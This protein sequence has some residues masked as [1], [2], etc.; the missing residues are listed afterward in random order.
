MRLQYQ[1][2]SDI[3]KSILSAGL[4]SV[5]PRKLINRKLS[6]KGNILKISGV[7][8]NLSGFAK[9]YTIGIGKGA[10]GMCEGLTDVL[11]E[12]LSGGIIISGTFYDFKTKKLISL[13]GDHPY[14]GKNSLKAGIAL[15]RFVQNIEKNDLVV[16]LTTGGASAM[17]QAYPDEINYKD[18]VNTNKLLIRSGADINEINC[19][20]KNLSTIKGGKLAEKIYPARIISLLISDVIGSDPGTIGSG[21]FYKDNSTPSDAINILKKYSLWESV[22]EGIIYYLK[23]KKKNK[24]PDKSFIDTFVLGKN[25]DALN[26]MQK[27]S[28]ELGIKSKII[29]SEESGDVGDAAK[30]YGI[31]IK[32]RIYSRNNNDESELLLFGGEFTVNVSGKG[33]GGRVQEF[34]LRLLLELKNVNHPF[35]IAGIGTDGKDGT[36]DSA[37]AWI[38]NETIGKCGN[39]PMRMISGYLNNNDSHNFFKRFNQL[40]FTGLTGTNVTDVFLIFLNRPIPR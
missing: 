34:L 26:G 18:I 13:A 27:K 32:N 23:N 11:G 40:I 2:F 5:N 25:I 1:K 17:V 4:D 7:N 19:V 30:R 29:T 16:G 9:I 8:F 3:Y 36:S 28:L 39:E 6:L 10:A 35:F 31:L 22:G 37:G 20:R 21:L 33:D 12:K 38:D 24:F 14:P 15:N